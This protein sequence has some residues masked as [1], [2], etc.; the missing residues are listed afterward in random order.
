MAHANIRKNECL[1][2]WGKWGR[3]TAV[4]GI[5]PKNLNETRADRSS[6]EAQNQTFQTR[7]T[8]FL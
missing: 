4:L 3:E 5:E 7:Y 6:Y 1:Q 2:N 8:S